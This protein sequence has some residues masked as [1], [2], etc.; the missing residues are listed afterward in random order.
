M[1]D[2]LHETL[3]VVTNSNQIIYKLKGIVQTEIS[4]LKSNSTHDISS[5][6][7]IANIVSIKNSRNQNRVTTTNKSQEEK[8]AN[9]KPVFVKKDKREL[10]GGS[11]RKK[12]ICLTKVDK[13]K[14]FEK[15]FDLKNEL[16]NRENSNGKQL[17]ASKIKL[18]FRNAFKSIK[19]NI[20]KS[21]K[22]N[23]TKFKED[24]AKPNKT[25]LEN[26]NV[27]KVK[28][29]KTGLDEKLNLSGCENQDEFFKR[30]QN[31][32]GENFMNFFNFSYDKYHKEEKTIESNNGDK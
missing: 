21:S 15:N 2:Y 32:L 7:S 17:S 27:N 5:D 30:L 16:Q 1:F 11:I 18:A 25:N 22:K 28:K 6:C 10:S 14:S 3:K 20:F 26:Y 19:G 4:K 29:N 31:N 8:E 23:L 12:K 9:I 13:T 24:I